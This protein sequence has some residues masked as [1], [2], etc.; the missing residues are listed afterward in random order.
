[1]VRS[2][3]DAFDS[4]CRLDG[5]ERLDDVRQNKNKAE[6]CHWSA[7]GQTSQ[8]RRLSHVVPRE[9]WDRSVVIE[10]LTFC[11]TRKLVRVL[12]VLGYSLSSFASFVMC[13]AAHSETK[14]WK[15]ARMSARSHLRVRDLYRRPGTSS[16]V[17]LRTCITRCFKEETRPNR[18]KCSVAEPT[19]HKQTRASHQQQ[20]AT[21]NARTPRGC[22]DPHPGLHSSSASAAHEVSPPNRP[23]STKTRSSS[24]LG[25]VFFE[26][27][28]VADILHDRLRNYTRAVLVG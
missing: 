18:L 17:P 6:S 1:M 19:K 5:N 14:S 10:L 20:Q 25:T 23:S 22:S 27:L 16:L 26:A 8:T 24:L 28:V 21:V 2:T 15:K 7:S 11:P 9:S 3:A 13:S 12:L 4:L